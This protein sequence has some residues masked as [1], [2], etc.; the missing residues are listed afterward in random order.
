MAS[1]VIPDSR[2]GRMKCTHC[3]EVLAASTCDPKKELLAGF[4]CAAVK[5][6]WGR[7]FAGVVTAAGTAPTVAVVTGPPPLES[8]SPQ[9]EYHWLSMFIFRKTPTRVSRT[10]RTTHTSWSRYFPSPGPRRRGRTTTVT[11]SRASAAPATTTKRGH[12]VSS[13]NAMAHC[14]FP[15]D[16][17]WTPWDDRW[18]PHGDWIIARG[19]HRYPECRTGTA[20]NTAGC[21]QKTRGLL[22]GAHQRTPGRSSAGEEAAWGLRTR[23]PRYDG[24]RGK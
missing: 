14:S 22:P 20:R 13:K 1:C 2:P 3:P 16:C 4:V 5:G 24:P 6:W 11:A 9:L 18:S 8:R 15:V 12:P 10:T 7:S 23:L 19:Q 17:P 21:W